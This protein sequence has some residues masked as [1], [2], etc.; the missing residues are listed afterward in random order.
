MGVGIRL[1]QILKRKG[2][3]IK[4]LSKISGVSLNT[5]YSITKRDSERVD[6]LVIMSI[7]KALNID[8]LEL[9]SKCETDPFFIYYN[10]KIHDKLNGVEGFEGI[11]KNGNP[12]LK[13][14]SLAESIFF[15]EIT[16]F[17]DEKYVKHRIDL[18]F[19]VLN[20]EG[21]RKA[22]ERVEELAEIPKY[23]QKS[24]KDTP[25]QDKK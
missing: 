2:L 4:D 7:A 16:G 8:P 14:G 25:N 10:T 5:L 15:S 12:I 19:S 18:A 6:I 23:Q 17:E 21:K 9:S 22:V 24:E 1:K 20:T 3:S 11:D 13:K